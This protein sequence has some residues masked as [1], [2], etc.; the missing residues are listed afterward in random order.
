MLKTF[1]GARLFGAAHGEGVPWVLALPGWEHTHLDFDAALSTSDAIALDLPGFG[2]APQPPEAWTTRQYADHVAPVLE[3]MAPRIVVLGHSFGGKV[4]V[5]LAA[6]HP[7]R[8]AALVLTGVPLVRPFGARRRRPAA[9]VRLAKALRRAHLVSDQRLEQARRKRGS[10]DYRRSSG[11]MRGVLVKS[12]NETH[13]AQ[14]SAFPG[15]V[16]L[17]WGAEDEQVP[18]AVADAALALCGDGHLEVIAGVGHFVP[19]DR[20]VA[21]AE[22]LARHRP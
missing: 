5:H 13:E 15:P 10:E 11:V 6:A 7:E 14:L 22:A 9:G 2:A 20:P 17:I 18:L 12:V 16:E 8:V 21:L 19:R 3:E 4:A 1:A